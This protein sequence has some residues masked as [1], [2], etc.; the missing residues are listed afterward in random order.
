[1][2]LIT[3]FIM[4]N[5]KSNFTRII[6]LVCIAILI[7]A[8]SCDRPEP[9]KNI[10]LQLYSLRDS[11]AGNVAG[12]I[13]KVSDMGY[14]YVETAGYRDGQFYGLDPV[15]FRKL[16]ETNGL[17]FTGSHT[18]RN[19]PD[20]STYAETMAWWDKCIDA[21]LA[22]GVKWIVQPF[23]GREGYEN[24]EGLKRYCDYFNEI[25]DKCRKKGIMFGYHNHDKEFSTVLDSITVYDFMLQNTDPEK[26]LFQIDLYWCVEGGK[27]P[28]DYF[29][30]YPGRFPIWHIKDEAEVGA[31]GKIDFAAIWEHAAQSGMKYAVVEVEKYNFEPFESCKMSLEYLNDSGFVI[32]PE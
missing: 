9:G 22:A 7:F 16:C 14:T 6:P 15:E 26:V 25:G 27:N 31:S 4:K 18:G 2:N 24:I 10:G 11:I 29:T 32:I 28:V 5:R 17:A 12:T 1:M 30:S 23:M 3:K 8:G 21:H 20:S 13:E 19:L